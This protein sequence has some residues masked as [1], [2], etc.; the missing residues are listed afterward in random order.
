MSNVPALL[1][2]IARREEARNNATIARLESGVETALVHLQYGNV[3]SAV[4]VLQRALGRCPDCKVKEG[5]TH[6]QWCAWMKEKT[7]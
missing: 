3:A 1:N 5:L 2:A 4:E 6:H 7:T